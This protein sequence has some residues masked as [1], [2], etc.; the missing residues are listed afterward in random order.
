MGNLILMQQAGDPFSVTVDV[1]AKR[2]LYCFGYSESGAMFVAPQVQGLA[3]QLRGPFREYWSSLQ[4]DPGLAVAGMSLRDLVCG[5]RLHP[6]AAFLALDALIKEPAA[7]RAQI[8]VMA[9]R[10]HISPMMRNGCCEVH[11]NSLEDE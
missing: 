8:R 11:G 5:A 3:E 9:A 7:A 6:V 4:Y 2:L 10:P 1:V